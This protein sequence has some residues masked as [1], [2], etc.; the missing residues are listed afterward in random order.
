MEARYWPG[1]PAMRKELAPPEPSPG[2][3]GPEVL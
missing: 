3:P 1:E 2:G